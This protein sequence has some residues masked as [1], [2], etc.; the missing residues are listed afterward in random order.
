LKLSDHDLTKESLQ[1]QELGQELRSIINNGLYEVEVTSAGEPAYDAPDEP[2]I[3][4]SLF[5]AQRRVY[6]GYLGSWYYV[7][8]TAL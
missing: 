5:G 8:L 2:R 4:L 7:S 6:F 1:I 3:V